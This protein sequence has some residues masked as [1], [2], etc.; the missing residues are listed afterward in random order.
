[1]ENI[2]RL[3]SM[4]I[5]ESVKKVL[6]NLFNF[7]GR[8]RR[9]ELWMY[10]LFY[11]LVSM[12]LM[13]IVKPWPVVS[14]IVYTL[15]HLSLWSVTVRRL[16]DRGHSGWWVTIAI[17]LSTFLQAYYLDMGYYEIIETINP[18]PEAAMAIMMD[19]IY[20]IGLLVSFFVNISILIFCVLD[21]KPEP[22]KYGLSPKYVVEE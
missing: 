5:G 22:N 6:S 19:P 2:K 7:K 16:H 10:W 11:F 1:M 14:F 8:A 17:L 20:N 3:P 21:S 15:L 12:V 18:D 13:F 9:S 4:T